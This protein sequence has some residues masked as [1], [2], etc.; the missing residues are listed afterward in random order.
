MGRLSR[1]E[2]EVNVVHCVNRCVRRGFHCRKVPVTGQDSKHRREGIRQRLEILAGAMK[3][4]M[5]GY[6]HAATVGWP[7]RLTIFRTFGP[8]QRMYLSI[9]CEQN[10]EGTSRLCSTWNC[11][12]VVILPPRSRRPSAHR[13]LPPAIASFRRS[14]PARRRDSSGSFRAHSGTSLRPARGLRFRIRSGGS[15]R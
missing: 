6:R 3:V 14:C 10:R 4:E 5:L 2:D 8:E 1:A 9:T 13:G 7:G 11:F 12:A 15:W